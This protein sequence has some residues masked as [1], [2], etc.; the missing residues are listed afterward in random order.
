MRARRPPLLIDLCGHP[1]SS[2][3]RVGGRR[4]SGRTGVGVAYKPPPLTGMGALPLAVVG[5]P[6]SVP[7]YQLRTGSGKEVGADGN[8]LMKVLYS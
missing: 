5:A 8:S 2:G 1:L 3:G 7:P 6:A 4:Q